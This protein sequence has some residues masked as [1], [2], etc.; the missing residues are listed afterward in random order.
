MAEML[1][2][3][4][5]SVVGEVI[6]VKEMKRSDYLKKDGESKFRHDCR[7]VRIDPMN[8]N[9]NHDVYVTD[10]QWAR[11]GMG[12]ILFEG[13]IVNVAMDV[14]K[15]D[16]TGY[17]DEDGEWVWHTAS[18]N[19][20]AGADNVGGAR[21]ISIYIKLGITPNIVN[22]F[23]NELQERRK[24]YKVLVPTAVKAI[25]SVEEIPDG[26][27]PQTVEETTDDNT[28]D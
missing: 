22:E 1:T 23:I 18:Y 16:E 24:A 10:D 17:K 15:K 11:Y 26:E 8:G 13:N 9:P 14:C 2:P 7:L 25:A 6:S 12:A 27:N 19:A 20:F 5:I 3:E 21:L 4:R 28:E